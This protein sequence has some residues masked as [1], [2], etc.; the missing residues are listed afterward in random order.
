VLLNPRLDPWKACDLGLVTAVH[1][2]EEL[3]GKVM[4]TALELAAGPTAAWAAGKALLNRA[5]GMDRLDFH[6]DQELAALV[7]SADSPE[8]ARGLD[9][10]FDRGRKADRA[11]PA[12]AGDPR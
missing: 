3:A 11:T 9:A 2:T 10:F 6:L 1:P 5:A 12:A 7:R 4:A 8:F